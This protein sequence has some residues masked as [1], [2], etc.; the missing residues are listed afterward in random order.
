MLKS[1]L[2][3]WERPGH[4]CNKNNLSNMMMSL[5]VRLPSSEKRIAMKMY[6]WFLVWKSLDECAVFAYILF[7]H[8]RDVDHDITIGHVSH[9]NESLLNDPLAL[10]LDIGHR[11]PGSQQERRRAWTAV[12]LLLLT[13]TG[14]LLG[15][16]CNRLMATQEERKQG[17]I[18]KEL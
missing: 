14:Y 8:L 17:E 18:N 10:D 16:H 3:W 7:P 12:L 15:G 9:P 11:S 4:R 6:I 1:P 2:G 5:R 13:E